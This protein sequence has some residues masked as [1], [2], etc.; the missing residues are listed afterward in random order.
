MI[1][2]VTTC[3]DTHT[4]HTYLYMWELTAYSWLASCILTSQQT[5]FKCTTQVNSW[6]VHIK[7][8]ASYH[9]KQITI[10]TCIQLPSDQLYSYSVDVS[11]YRSY[12]WQLTIQLQLRSWALF[13]NYLSHL[14]LAQVTCLETWLSLESNIIR[15]IIIIINCLMSTTT[16]DTCV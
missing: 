4:L 2:T 8:I 5:K 9:Q 15:V 16:K 12:Q 1:Y 3:I 14:P 13:W 6:L 10:E 7:P 11:F